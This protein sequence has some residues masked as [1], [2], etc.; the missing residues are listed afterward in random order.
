[1]KTTL[2]LLMAA[3][4]AAFAEP[5]P[6]EFPVDAGALTAAALQDALSGKTYAVKPAEGPNWRWQF[7]ANGYFFLNV[8]D[9]SD[10]GK[11]SAK[12]GALCSEGRKINASCNE[13]RRQGADL[14]LKRDN[15]EVV[16]MTLQ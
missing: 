4:T 2:L 7:N 3:T 13:V 15:G 16:R 5:A 9:F 1:M 8:G 11:W 14:Y 12:E 6:R 10:S